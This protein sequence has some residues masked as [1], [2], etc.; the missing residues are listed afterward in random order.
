MNGIHASQMLENAPDVNR[1]TG[2]EKENKKCK[3]DNCFK[4]VHAKKYCN[5]HYRQLKRHGIVGMRTIYTS[6]EICINKNIAKIKLY[7]TKGQEIAET[8]ID[9]EDIEK[10]RKHKWGLCGCGYVKNSEVGFL[11]HF[12]FG[13]PPKG[14]E[15]DHKSRNIL[16]NRKQNLRFVTR[17]QSNAN[18]YQATRNGKLT[19]SV[20]KGV[21]RD[22]A[23]NKW[24][25]EITKDKKKRHIGRFDSEI[26]AA[27]L[28]DIEAIGLFGEYALTNK[29]LGLL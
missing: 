3:V 11:H 9:I 20:Y 22:R 6:N 13:L 25:A 19:S 2:I 27:I 5:T 28:Y 7:N 1:F 15:V 10:L 8:I 4:K 14:C 16:D 29:M 17:S 12:V 21:Y 26:E 23:R 24:C 18:S